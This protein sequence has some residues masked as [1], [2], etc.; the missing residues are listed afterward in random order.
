MSSCSSELGAAGAF[1]KIQLLDRGNYYRGLLVLIRSDRTIDAREYEWMIQFGQVL[2]FDWRFCESAIKD[3]LDNKHILDEPMT[4]SNRATAECFM[5]DAIRLALIDGELHP[6]EL[7][8]LKDVAR[9]NGLENE[10]LFAEINRLH[11]T[12]Q[13]IVLPHLSS[14]RTVASGSPEGKL[15]CK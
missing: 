14:S 6:K 2:D 13:P 1:M 7:T 8:W 5:R 15:S 4:F 11:G 3:L 12:Q 10:W 9:V